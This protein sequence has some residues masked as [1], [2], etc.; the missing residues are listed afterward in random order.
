MNTMS[1]KPTKSEFQPLFVADLFSFIDALIRLWGSKGHR[2]GSQ[3]TETYSMQDYK[4]LCAAATI[5]ASLVD[6]Q[7]DI[8]RF[9]QLV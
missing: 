7:T 9:Y 8:Q 6:I 2:S 4:S 1:Q 5:C 3:Q